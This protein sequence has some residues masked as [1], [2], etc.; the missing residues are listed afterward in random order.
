MRKIRFVR[1]FIVFQLFFQMEI[2]QFNKILDCFTQTKKSFHILF[3]L[4][5]GSTSHFSH[6]SH[7][8][9]LKT[10]WF[11]W[12]KK[13]CC[14]FMRHNAPSPNPECLTSKKTTTT[15]KQKI[16]LFTWVARSL[17][18]LSRDRNLS[19][20][21]SFNQSFYK[22]CRFKQHEPLCECVFAQMKFIR[23]V[24]MMF[25]YF[26]KESTPPPSWQCEPGVNGAEKEEWTKL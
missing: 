23:I 20:K 10:A 3:L 7:F 5:I 8:D 9:P 22:F 1:S 2:E 16:F 14:L 12:F 11:S 17:V 26:H 15:N 18:R 21:C 13:P 24:M 4:P 25:Q 19:S 6:Y